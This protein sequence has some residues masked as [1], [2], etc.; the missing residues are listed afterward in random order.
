MLRLRSGVRRSGLSPGRHQAGGWGGVV[1]QGRRHFFD[2]LYVRLLV[3]AEVVLLEQRPVELVAPRLDLLDLGRLHLEDREVRVIPQVRLALLERRVQI[4]GVWLI[5]RPP[6]RRRVGVALRR[7]RRRQSLHW[8]HARR[9]EHRILQQLFEHI[10]LVWALDE[11]LCST[12]AASILQHQ[13]DL[14]VARGA[15]AH[16]LVDVTGQLCL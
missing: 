13:L 4:S 9:R 5:R 3:V 1:K 10:G 14:A 16:L 15:R 12:S 7:R 6:G 11:V 8:V 2:Q